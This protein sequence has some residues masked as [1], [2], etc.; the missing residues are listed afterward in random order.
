MK[1]LIPSI[2]ITLLVVIGL[3][4]WISAHAQN[5][6][7][8]AIRQAIEHYFRGHATGQG[9]HFR[10]VFHPDSKLFAVRDGKY[11][12]LTSEE[13]IARASGKPQADEAQ[14]KRQIESIDVAGNAAMVK[15]V[16][17]YP[18]VKFT[19]YMSMLKIDGEW[20]IINKTFYA[21]PKPAK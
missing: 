19:D 1:K 11:W 15:I 9:E 13:Y 8:T 4:T 3:A 18:Q 21:E 10:K 5:P 17:D 2:V 16:L 6:E 12:Q 20:K 7:E 14:R